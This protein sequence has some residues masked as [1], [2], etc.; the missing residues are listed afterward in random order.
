MVND[1]RAFLAQGFRG[2]VDSSLSRSTCEQ[3]RPVLAHKIVCCKGGPFLETC[4]RVT[5]EVISRE[6]LEVK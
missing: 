1:A 4:N 3:I 5:G 2:S 6:K